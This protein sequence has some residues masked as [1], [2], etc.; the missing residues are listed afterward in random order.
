VSAGYAGDVTIPSLVIGKVEASSVK[1]YLCGVN[2]QQK[3]PCVSGGTIVHATLGL[4]VATTRVVNWDLWTAVDDLQSS[5]FKTQF[6]TIAPL[7]G[8]YLRLALSALTN[9][10]RPELSFYTSLQD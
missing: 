1:K 3:R 5:K 9:F 8:Q 4:H 7:L 6:A 2:L 10:G